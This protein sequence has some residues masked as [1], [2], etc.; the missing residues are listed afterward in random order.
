MPT[1]ESRLGR[2]PNLSEIS[3]VIIESRL[4]ISFR[5]PADGQYPEYHRA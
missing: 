4:V 3:D 2:S 1:A 5:L